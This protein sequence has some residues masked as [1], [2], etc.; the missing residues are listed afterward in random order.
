[1]SSPR[2]SPGFVRVAVARFIVL[3]YV[4]TPILCQS[5]SSDSEKDRRVCMESNCSGFYWKDHKIV[6]EEAG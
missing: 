5:S 4:L 3:H 2:K 6:D 1:M